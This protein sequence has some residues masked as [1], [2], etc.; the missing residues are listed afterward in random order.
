MRQWLGCGAVLVLTAACGGTGLP[1]A[2]SASSFSPG[3]VISLPAAT[4]PLEM[5]DGW[6]PWSFPQWQ[7][8]LGESLNLDTTIGSVVEE[9]D[10]CV[11]NLRQV[12]DSRSSC[13]RFVVSVPSTGWLYGYL[14]WD[15]SAPGFTP[16]SAG[17]IVLVRQ[18]GRFAASAWLRPD[19]E[20]AA[21]VEPGDYT[22]LVITYGP[23]SLPFQLTMNLR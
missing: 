8:G 4:R 23:V 17:E 20:V 7:P 2:P 19:L 18:D 1:T 14:T 11:F 10:V 15:A 12:W 16:Y 22:V 9:N 21:R 5:A 3:S 13:R 6:L